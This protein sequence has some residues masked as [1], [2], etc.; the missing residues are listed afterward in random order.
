MH[1][2]SFFSSHKNN[3]TEFKLLYAP[4]G[5]Q[6]VAEKE[7]PNSQHHVE[8]QVTREETHE[9]V[10]GEHEGFHSMMLQVPVRGWAR[11]FQNPHQ[12]GCVKQNPL[13]REYTSL[14]NDQN[15]SDP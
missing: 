9:P 2:L 10:S 14:K 13:L 1:I 12:Q 7:V 6:T 4:H 11:P 5:G 15:S 3:I 8:G